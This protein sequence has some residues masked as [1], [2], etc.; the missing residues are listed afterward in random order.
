MTLLQR[1]SGEYRIRVTSDSGMVHDTGWFNNLILDIGLN[2][3]GLWTTPGNAFPIQFIRLGTGNT[4]VSASQTSLIS[5]VSSG[6]A[7]PIGTNPGPTKLAVR[8]LFTPGQVSGLI[9]EVG[10]GWAST[11]STLFSR[12]LLSTPLAVS[13]TDQVEVF[14][15]VTKTP[16]ASPVSGSVIV[17]GISYPYNVYYKCL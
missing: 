8:T 15:T 16:V 12:S 14:Y 7:G 10:A 13:L 17:N 6:A 4:A 3:V 9:A 2:Q 11:G 1:V 5:Q